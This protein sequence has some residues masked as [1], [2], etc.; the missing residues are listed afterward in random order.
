PTWPDLPVSCDALN[1]LFYDLQ[2]RGW[3]RQDAGDMQVFLMYGLSQRY[4]YWPAEHPGF[5]D[6]VS[7]VL[8][9][10]RA[11]DTIGKNEELRKQFSP[12]PIVKLFRATEG[13]PPAFDFL[14]WRSPEM[15]ARSKGWDAYH[16]VRAANGSIEEARE[17]WRRAF[18]AALP[19]Y[20]TS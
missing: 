8:A 9:D 4:H 12:A 10:E 2:Q 20:S 7:S 6:F 5:R 15:I 18:R 19:G 11:P 16:E 14:H 13:A 3:W 17:A 1:Q